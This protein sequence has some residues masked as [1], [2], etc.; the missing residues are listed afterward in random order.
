MDTGSFSCKNRAMF[1][2]PIWDSLSTNGFDWISP[3]I[4][5]KQFG[6]TSIMCCVIRSFQNSG[7]IS[8]RTMTPKMDS[9]SFSWAYTN[10]I[11]NTKSF[12]AFWTVYARWRHCV[13]SVIQFIVI[14]MSLKCSKICW[15]LT[16]THN[17][18]PIS[19]KSF[20]HS[21]MFHSRFLQIVIRT[22]ASIWILISPTWF[23]L[24]FILAFELNFNLS[25]LVRL[26]RSLDFVKNK[27]SVIDFYCQFVSR[28]WNDGWSQMQWL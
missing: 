24:L 2:K 23:D 1:R 9:I 14:D 12:N 20:T 28:Y 27:K 11:R 7:N 25:W 8:V 26:I 3:K 5:M 16:Y 10:C 19:P 6:W 22:A 18:R 13:D 4:F 15:K 21:T 17:C